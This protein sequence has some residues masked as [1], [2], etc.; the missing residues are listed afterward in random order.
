M[1]AGRA[2]VPVH[3]I[4]RELVRE[5]TTAGLSAARTRGRKGGRPTVM[6]PDKL[7]QA[8]RL[9]DERPHTVEAI[10]RILGVSRTS[11]YRALRATP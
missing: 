10:A 1:T 9:Y 3:I 8:R 6:T 7:K 2:S 11:V 5:R 4:E